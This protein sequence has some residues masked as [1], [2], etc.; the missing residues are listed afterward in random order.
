M[1][2]TPLSSSPSPLHPP[3]GE[4]P[5]PRPIKRYAGIVPGHSSAPALSRSLH[6]PLPRSGKGVAG[7]FRC[8]MDRHRPC[9]S[10]RGFLLP[11]DF[12]GL[13]PQEGQG[14]RQPLAGLSCPLLRYANDAPVF[15]AFMPPA[16]GAQA[17]PPGA[18]RPVH[19]RQASRQPSSPVTSFA[20]FFCFRVRR[21][22]GNWAWAM[23]HPFD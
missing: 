20:L 16:I 11:A 18:S 21:A 6:L 2:V 9:F 19:F 22:A 17:A 3:K 7:H 23:P 4:F 8:P 14:T 5:T 15:R 12:P 13:P 1:A 10:S